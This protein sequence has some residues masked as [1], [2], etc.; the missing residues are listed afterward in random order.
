VATA[1][2]PHDL[3][4]GVAARGEPGANEPS[5][6]AIEDPLDRGLLQKLGRRKLGHDDTAWLNR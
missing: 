3:E 2:A 6:D 1:F 4:Q 5:E